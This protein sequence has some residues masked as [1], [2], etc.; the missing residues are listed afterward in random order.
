MADFR[1]TLAPIHEKS[2][3]KFWCQKVLPTVYDDS[4]SY[5]ELL[6]KVVY[7]LNENTQDLETVNSNV[8]ALYNSYVQLQDYV[9]D[10]IDNQMPR[11]VEEKIDEMAE[12]GTLTALIA[13]YIDPYFE[14]QTEYVEG[15]LDAQDTAI[16][17]AKSEQDTTISNAITSQNTTI[18]NAISSQNTTISEAISD[19]N[20]DIA[21]MQ[22][23][24]STFISSHNTSREEVT[25]WEAQNAASGLHYVGQT[26]VLSES[27]DDYDYIKIGFET[28][29]SSRYVEFNKTDFINGLRG[30]GIVVPVIDTSDTNAIKNSYIK[31]ACTD[32]DDHTH[33]AV[34]ECGNITWDG[35]NTDDAVATSSA[36]SADWDGG[37]ITKIMGIM[38]TTNAELTDIRVGADGTVYP[39]AGDA[40]RG[41]VTD[42]NEAIDDIVEFNV[43]ENL[44]NPNMTLDEGFVSPSTG[45]YTANSSYRTTDYVPVTG[46][47]YFIMSTDTNIV[48]RALFISEWDA[49]KQIIPMPTKT[50]EG[51]GDGTHYSSGYVQV[52]ANAVYVRVT[53]QKT[54]PSLDLSK[55][56]YSC[57]DTSTIPTFVPYFTPYYTFTNEIISGYNIRP[58]IHIYASDGINNFYDSM[59]YA[60]TKGN[61]DVYIH[62]GTYTYTNAFVEQ[63]RSASHR[64]VPV[65]NGCKYIF[66]QGAEIV[67]EY[68]GSSSADVADLFS[69]L[70]TWN[71]GGDF[72]I[73]NLKLTAKNVCYAFHDEANGSSDAITHTFR[74]CNISLDNTA[75]GVSGNQYSKAIGGGLGQ[76]EL[77][78][79]ENCIFNSVN[80]AMTSYTKATVSYH[81]ASNS[82]DTNANINVTGCYFIN[83]TFQGSDL[84]ANTGIKPTLLLT[85]CSYTQNPGITNTWTTYL[86]NNIVHS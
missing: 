59:Y 2:P 78:V 7:Y 8:E 18:A 68:T 60:Y 21:V 54:P 57:D 81:G 76:K 43:S 31:I 1:P 24:M 70:D 80:P 86:F 82:A 36:T 63:I 46:G 15:R 73:I 32:T 3:F 51:S 37:V 77:V 30:A 52:S 35:E 64:G 22:S 33:F 19:Q 6:T 69:P 65:G 42:L 13:T 85:N 49:D 25:L 45:V 29:A 75:L 47:K 20:T 72:E 4:L 5:Y 12:D 34:T 14:E 50:V 66:E 67:C 62:K 27:P 53:Y 55:L 61:T 48:D 17:S 79:I 16:A 38:H 84:P 44:L 41:Q 28:M 39:T 11:L 74:N 83:G 9:N 40:V 26:I 58:I 10:Y 23:Q 71:T 56:M